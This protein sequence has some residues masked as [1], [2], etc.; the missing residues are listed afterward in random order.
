V[1]V[2]IE[3]GPDSPVD[4]AQLKKAIES[5]IRERLLVTTKVTLVP[6]N[7]LPRETYKSKLVDYS[8]VLMG[9]L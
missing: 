2:Q 9:K 4:Q 7:S 8:D 6:Y 3:L 1:P 5:A